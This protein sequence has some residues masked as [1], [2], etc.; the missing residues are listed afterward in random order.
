MNGG[1]G[2]T[3]EHAVVLLV[4]T[5]PSS[6][7]PGDLINPPDPGYVS[8]VFRAFWDRLA[9]QAPYILLGLLVLLASLYLGKLLKSAV[10]RGLRK[11]STEAHVHLVVGKLAY[12][13]TIL[14]GLVAGLSIAGV[15][16]AV[17]AASLG[18]ASVGLGFALSDILSNFVAG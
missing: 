13:G 3:V 9:E 2:A 15:N 7:S 5:P 4:Q 1:I 8:K 14:A 17:M 16:L 11:T 12:F 10:E 18:L 6:T